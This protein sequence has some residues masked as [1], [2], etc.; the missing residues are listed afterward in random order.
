MATLTYRT[1]DEKR[2]KLQKLAKKAGVSVNRMIDDW[3]TYAIAESEAFY[4]F[5]VMAEHGKQHQGEAV[6]IL[7]SKAQ[8]KGVED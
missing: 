6:R 5:Q 8:D 4:R 3:A 2:D 1:T 7:D